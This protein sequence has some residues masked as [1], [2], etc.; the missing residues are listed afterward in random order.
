MLEELNNN[1]MSTNTTPT[2]F[3]VASRAKE[4]LMDLKKVQKRSTTIGDDSGTA[5]I[6]TCYTEENIYVASVHVLGT[7]M[8]GSSKLMQGEE[9]G[10]LGFAEA[11]AMR[12]LDV[13][14][15]INN[16][17]IE[18]YGIETDC[19]QVVQTINSGS[20]INS[21]F[22]G[23]IERYK[24]RLVAKGFTQTYGID[25]SETFA[26]VAKLNTVRILLS[27]A[28]NLDWPLHQ[29]D[30]K[31]AF[32][33]GDLEEEVYMDI[34]PGFEDRFGSN[35][36]K[37]NKSLYGLKQSPR[38][39][40]EK[41][42]Q[43]MKKQGVKEKLAADF[44]IKDLGSMRYFLGMEVARSKDGIV[45]SQQKYI[46]DLLKETG[47]SGCRPADTPMDP[48]AKLWEKGN[49]PVDTG[50][51]QRLVGK[52]IYLS[53]TRPDI[54]FSVSVVSQFMHS[55]FE[56]HLEAVYRILRYLKATPRKGLFFRKTNERNVSIFTDA[57]WA[58]S[59][60]DRRST[61][62]YCAYVWGNL[63]TW[64][65]KKQGVVARSSAEAEFRAMAQGDM[66]LGGGESG[67]QTEN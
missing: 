40:F 60:T 2:L 61:S 34:P 5:V 20:K 52:L 28:A 47:M 67:S 51:Y 32:L 26:L 66:V 41:F 50:R 58:G 63:V 14:R 45:V 15:W 29:L 4:S 18:V 8:V 25:Y 36:C 55:P 24:A 43:S 12:V 3:D 44:E 9:M 13:L 35:V 16:S 62:G 19:L 11:D 7:R 49:V 30:V 23:S 46:I 59:I 6:Q 42:T 56:E 1:I 48:N 10:C 57:D 22:D 37:L 64:R 54:A 53:H 39:W 65:S 21:E 33:N 38:A 27:V 31:N 17:H